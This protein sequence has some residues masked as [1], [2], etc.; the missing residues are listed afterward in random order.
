MGF[1]SHGFRA[2]QYNRN[3][4]IGY[5]ARAKHKK[6]LYIG[7]FPK[8]FSG[9]RVSDDLS[10]EERGKIR[11]SITSAVNKRRVLDMVFVT[12]VL[13]LLVWLILPMLK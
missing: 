2:N 11:S 1:M 6:S 12:A 3:L 10:T 9:G 8:S 7:S 4:Q 13:V 5:K